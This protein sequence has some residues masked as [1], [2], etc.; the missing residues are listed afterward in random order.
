MAIKFRRDGS[1]EVCNLHVGKVRKELFP[2]TRPV[3]IFASKDG[4]VSQGDRRKDLER[5]IETSARRIYRS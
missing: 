5:S 2:T 1:V 4:R 3:W